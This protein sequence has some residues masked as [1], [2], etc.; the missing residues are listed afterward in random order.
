V[1]LEATG[2]EP[3]DFGVDYLRCA[4]NRSQAYR[5]NLRPKNRG[6]LLI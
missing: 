3:N 1:A 4:R 6:D 2:I 5:A